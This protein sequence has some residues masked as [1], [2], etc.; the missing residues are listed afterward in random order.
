MAL[1]GSGQISMSQIAA[2]FGGT[3]PHSLSEYYSAAP[4]VPAS[5]AIKFSDFYGKSSATTTSNVTGT[6][7]QDLADTSKISGSTNTLGDGSPIPSPTTF[8][9][10]PSTSN[11]DYDGSSIAPAISRNDAMRLTD[12]LKTAFSVP[13]G[14]GTLTVNFSPPLT[15]DTGLA[16]YIEPGGAKGVCASSFFSLNGNNVQPTCCINGMPNG[17][18][19]LDIWNGS[20][21]GAAVRSLNQFSGN[22]ISIDGGMTVVHGIAINGVIIVGNYLTTLTFA[23]TTN[24]G[25]FGA[26]TEVQQGGNSG[27]VLRNLPGS[28]QLVISSYQ[29]TWSTGQPIA[30]A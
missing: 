2:E 28:R 7:Y 20:Y 8:T 29:N 15:G 12:G 24:F 14:S 22:A 9:V 26:G 17:A 27:R 13:G 6:G 11:F 23:D 30:I 5:G 21:V 25:E 10:D 18:Q 3:A 19:W 1:P 16:L 4:G